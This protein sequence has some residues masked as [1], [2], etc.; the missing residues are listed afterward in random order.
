MSNNPSFVF[1]PGA[2]HGPRTWDKVISQL[3]PNGYP[4]SVITLP[5]TSG[6]ASKGFD[7]D[8]EATQEAIRLQISQGHNVVL[9][10]HSYSGQIITSAVK[11]FS[12]NPHDG[13]KPPA[14]PPAHVIGLAMMATGHTV[15]RSGDSGSKP[16]GIADKGDGLATILF[17]AREK[18]YHDLP[19]KEAKAAVDRLKPQSMKALGGGRQATY[20]GWHDVPCWFFITMQDQALPPDIQKEFAK[21]AQ[22]GGADVTVREVESS[23]SPMLSR[24]QETTGFLADAATYF[25]GK[26]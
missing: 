23:H 18:M 1:V 22:D 21:M 20:A 11:G 6:D 4:C 25:V 2:W 7:D 5:S 13:S 17:D 8:V 16:I 12:R 26:T 19:E 14:N 15:K 3:E 24:P 9:V 10:G